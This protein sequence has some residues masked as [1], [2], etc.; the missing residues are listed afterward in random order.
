MED[1]IVIN[2]FWLNQ[3]K[4]LKIQKKNMY[5]IL[6]I[7]FVGDIIDFV[8]YKIQKMKDFQIKKKIN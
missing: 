5:Q 6:K 2:L 4:N 8:K 3:V 1:L 7:L